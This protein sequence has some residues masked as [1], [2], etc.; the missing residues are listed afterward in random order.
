VTRFDNSS[1]SRTAGVGDLA[2]FENYYGYYAAVRVLSVHT[3]H[4]STTGEH[5]L[6]FQ[7]LI[8]ADHTPVFGE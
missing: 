6:Q 4:S 1:R 7:Y 3:R 8:Q 2:I 5:E